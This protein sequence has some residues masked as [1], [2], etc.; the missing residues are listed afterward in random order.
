MQSQM[1]HRSNRNGNAVEGAAVGL[2]VE[3]VQYSTI[4]VQRPPFGSRVDRRR[5]A[6]RVVTGTV[7]HTEDVEWEIEE[8][9]V[10]QRYN[11]DFRPRFGGADALELWRRSGLE[12]FAGS[13]FA[14]LD[15]EAASA[16]SCTEGE[17][18]AP[19][20]FIPAGGQD[21]TPI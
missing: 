13:R 6:G 16:S 8:S 7:A 18:T 12:Q 5:L 11:S 15:H 2:A 3:D 4:I 1:L 14:A 19:Q 17:W 10:P 20:P 21:V 9:L